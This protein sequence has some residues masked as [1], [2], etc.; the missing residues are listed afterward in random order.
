MFEER[1]LAA[2]AV[3]RREAV[4]QQTDRPRQ[5]RAGSGTSSRPAAVVRAQMTVRDVSPNGGLD[6]EG[7][8]SAYE[9]PYEMY[10][11]FGIY[12]E[13]V[14]LGAGTRTLARADLDVPL[15]LQ[16]DSMRRIARTSNGS[17]QIR[18]SQHGLEVNAPGLD[19]DDKDVAYIVPK[20]RAGLVDEMSFMFSITRGSWSPDFTEYR[21]QE[22]DLHRGD[23]SIVGYGANPNTSANIRTQQTGADLIPINETQLLRYV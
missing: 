23:V 1:G 22:Y 9:Q 8:A 15:V 14:S 21:I 2:A 13:V 5:R 19:P 11:A 17:L 20:I 4:G 16:H 10:D 18:E 7:I 3:A 6:F 12:S